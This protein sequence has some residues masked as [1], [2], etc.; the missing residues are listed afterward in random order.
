MTYNFP[1]LHDVK[2]RLNAAIQQ[3]VTSFRN[4]EWGSLSFYMILIICLVFY[5]YLQLRTTYNNAYATTS[6]PLYTSTQ[7]VRLWPLVQTDNVINLNNAGT[8][9]ATP[10]GPTINNFYA[11][12]SNSITLVLNAARLIKKGEEDGVYWYEDSDAYVFSTVYSNMKSHEITVGRK[13][14]LVTL[15]GITEIGTTERPNYEYRFGIV[16]E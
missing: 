16:E 6:Y 4:K 14:F 3:I 10:I 11:H 12:P 1:L 15:F 5:A 8:L 13:T 2:S 7:T 9:T